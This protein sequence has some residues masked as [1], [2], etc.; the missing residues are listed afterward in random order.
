MSLV[1]RPSQELSEKQFGKLSFSDTK[2][3]SRRPDSVR[4]SVGIVASVEREESAVARRFAGGFAVLQA[5][6]VAESLVKAF[7]GADERALRK[8][9]SVSNGKQLL[10]AC[11]GYRVDVFGVLT[12]TL[13]PDL[14]ALWTAAAV[15]DAPPLSAPVCP[16]FDFSLAA[17]HQKLG[18]ANIMT[19]EQHRAYL[20]NLTVESLLKNTR[21]TMDKYALERPVSNK[22]WLVEWLE[23]LRILFPRNAGYV[24]FSGRTEFELGAE[25][26]YGA[27]L[28]A[29]YSPKV[30]LIV[31]GFLG[32]WSGRERTGEHQQEWDLFYLSKKMRADGVAS[33]PERM[34]WLCFRGVHCGVGW[35]EGEA[36]PQRFWPGHY[37][38]YYDVRSEDSVRMLCSFVKGVVDRMVQNYYA[39]DGEKAVVFSTVLTCS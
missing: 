4:N 1:R 21:A 3:S 16:A 26:D 35:Q 24:V 5:G 15:R 38:I 28:T 9:Q 37:D 17:L 8:V 29:D 19:H 2:V 33:F 11:V 36:F 30:V 20:D 7:L 25:L 22:E 6:N 34:F 10:D 31:K 14:A 13:L 23:V 32:R 27:V 12:S 18:S 39:D